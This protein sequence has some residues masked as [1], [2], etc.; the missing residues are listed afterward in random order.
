METTDISRPV[1]V[2]RL[3]VPD[4]LG[5]VLILRRAPDSTDGGRWCLPGGKIDYGDTAEHAAIRELQEETSLRAT[6]LRF[7]FYQDGLPLAPGR[8]HCTNLYFEC[9]VEGEVALNEESIEAAWISREEA[10]RYDLSFRND[11]GLARYW[12]EA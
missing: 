10:P 7:L 5:R 2:V 1:P 4:A 11:E 12:A 6:N 9:A 3:I 8:M